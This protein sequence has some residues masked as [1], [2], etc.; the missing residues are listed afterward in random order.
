MASSKTEH[1]QAI[2]KDIAAFKMTV[3]DMRLSNGDRKRCQKQLYL[4]TD[5]LQD[6]AD[7]MD[8]H[9]QYDVGAEDNA[10]DLAGEVFEKLVGKLSALGGALVD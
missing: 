1:K 10:F 2:Q 6:R 5:L 3:I 4:V 8:F 7:E 9:S